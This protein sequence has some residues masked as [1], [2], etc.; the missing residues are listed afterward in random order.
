MILWIAEQR[1]NSIMGIKKIAGKYY[2]T[3]NLNPPL[4]PEKSDFI[5]YPKPAKPEPKGNS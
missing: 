1:M 2:F 5:F 4:H 3:P